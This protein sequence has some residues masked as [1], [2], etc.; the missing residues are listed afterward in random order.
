MGMNLGYMLLNLPSQSENIA[1]PQMAIQ[2]SSTS[3]QL[4]PKPLEC[5][6]PTKQMRIA[7]EPEDPLG[8]TEKVN[9]GP[10]IDYDISNQ[11]MIT[12][13]VTTTTK[14]Q[15]GEGENSELD[16]GIPFLRA[17][18]RIGGGVLWT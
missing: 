9:E 14:D 10:D 8:Q 15:D 3:M 2:M 13:I 12:N 17:R 1:P 18:T 11:E 4:V 7:Y 5:E 16:W 6:T